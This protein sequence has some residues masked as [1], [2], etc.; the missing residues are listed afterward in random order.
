MNPPAR[1]MEEAHTLDVLLDVELPLILRF[2]STQL[3]FGEVMGLHTG[4]VI[5]FA[6][7]SEAPVELLVNGRVVARG[8]V[9]MV[10]GNYGVRITEIA[11]RRERSIAVTEESPE[12]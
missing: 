8:E 10:R 9:V 1:T 6:G 7:A 4:S 3:A 12:S 5:E 2:G 11:S